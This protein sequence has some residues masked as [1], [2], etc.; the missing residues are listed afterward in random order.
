VDERVLVAPGADSRSPRHTFRAQ[1]ARTG[2]ARQVW[3]DGWA[4]DLV[5]NSH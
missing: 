3:I 2:D 4:H 1:V 5:A